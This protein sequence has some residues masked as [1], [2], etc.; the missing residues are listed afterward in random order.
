[1][2]E[3]LSILCLTSQFLARM[4]VDVAIARDQTYARA[5]LDSVKLTTIDFGP[6][7]SLSALPCVLTGARAKTTLDPSTL[8]GARRAGE[9]HRA[10][11][12]F[13]I[14]IATQMDTAV[15]EC[16]TVHHIHLC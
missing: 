11:P 5:I 4:D 8:A 6:V 3:F 15:M 2:F 14:Q 10:Q 1:M 7:T 12:A 13:A 16:L 9:V